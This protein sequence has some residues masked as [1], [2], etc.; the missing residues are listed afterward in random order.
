M[1]HLSL[2]R[3]VIYAK[4]HSSQQ[5]RILKP[6]T[7]A[8]EIPPIS[9]NLTEDDVV[10]K[11]SDIATGKYR[12]LYDGVQPHINPKTGHYKY[13]IK[14]CLVC[15]KYKDNR[16]FIDENKESCSREKYIVCLAIF[17]IGEKVNWQKSDG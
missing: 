1:Q 11:F 9:P 15:V 7:E 2:Q 16:G 4:S 8:P 3:V 17:L 14:K 13:G 6:T 10:G 5:W 12:V